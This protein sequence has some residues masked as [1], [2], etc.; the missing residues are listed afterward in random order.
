MVDN[1]VYVANSSGLVQGFD[2]SGLKDGEEPTQVFRF[3]TGDDTDAAIVGDED[4]YLYVG[5]TYDAPMNARA[6]AVGQMMKL[7]PRKPDDPIVWSMNDPETIPDPSHAGNRVWGALAT[8]ALYRDLVIFALEGG[9]VVAIDRQTGQER[10][11][12]QMHEQV[13]T[14]PTVVDG[15]MV[16]AGCGSGSVFAYD[17]SDTR[18]APTQLWRVDTGLCIESSPAIWHGKI[19]IGTEA[20]HSISS[21]AGMR[22]FAVPGATVGPTREPARY[23]R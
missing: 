4:G 16:F 11:R 3:W 20:S 13:W 18:Q 22:A 17:V 8:P 21:N 7:D 15:V 10:W 9:D 1:T 14:S 5:S 23:V 2:I 12:L 6:R 19:Y